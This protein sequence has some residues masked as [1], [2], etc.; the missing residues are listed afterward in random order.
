MLSSLYHYL[1]AVE[2]EQE[3]E[4][5]PK[6]VKQRH[7]LHEQIRKSNVNLK[8]IE[9][10]LKTETNTIPKSEPIEIPRKNKRRR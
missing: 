1:G 2:T 7:L 10:V 3:I 5:C 9:V 4:A 6:Q 8:P